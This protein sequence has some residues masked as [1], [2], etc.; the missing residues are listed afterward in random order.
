M[1]PLRM[2]VLFHLRQPVGEHDRETTSDVFSP[3]VRQQELPKK[4]AVPTPA[5]ICLQTGLQGD[6][7][8]QTTPDDRLLQS[9]GLLCL[10]TA[11]GLIFLFLKKSRKLRPQASMRRAFRQVAISS[12]HQ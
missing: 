3:W 10:Q 11:I 9:P 4:V 8:Q 12:M 1:Q 5:E 2:S 6:H 7:V